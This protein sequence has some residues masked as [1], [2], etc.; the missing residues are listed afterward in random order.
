MDLGVQRFLVTGL[1]MSSWRSLQLV[2]GHVRTVYEHEW[3]EVTVLHIGDITLVSVTSALRQLRTMCG[4]ALFVP[5][6]LPSEHGTP[7][8]NKDPIRDR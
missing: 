5:F 7:I 8:R 1:G 6:V 2:A 4:F 3:I